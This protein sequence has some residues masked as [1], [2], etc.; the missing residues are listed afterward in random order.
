MNRFRHVTLWPL[1]PLLPL[2]LLVATLALAQS[3]LTQLRSEPTSASVAAA[4]KPVRVYML[5]DP[6]SKDWY[7]LAAFELIEW[8]PQAKAEVWTV[9]KQALDAKALMFSKRAKGSVVRAFLLL[10][11]DDR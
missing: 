1:L 5:Q 11:V 10:A 4:E 3:S 9:K 7:S 6:V 2:L 8:G